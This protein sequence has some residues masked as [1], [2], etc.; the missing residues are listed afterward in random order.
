MVFDCSAPGSSEYSNKRKY[1]AQYVAAQF[2]VRH[3]GKE[4]NFTVGDGV[5]YDGFYNAPLEHGRDY[6]IILRAVSQWKMVGP[7]VV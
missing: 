7:I 3:V 5:Y 6:Y 1:Q 4:M 2:Q